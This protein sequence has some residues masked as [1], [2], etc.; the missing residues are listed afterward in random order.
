M[1]LIRSLLAALALVAAC[2]PAAAQEARFDSFAC[3][4][5]D[6]QP[7][8][9]P[10]QFRNPILAGFYPDPTVARVGEDYY[11]VASIRT[12]D[13]PLGSRGQP[14][15]WGRRQQHLS[16][17]ATTRVDF[18]PR[19]NGDR[20][21]IAALQTEDAFYLLSVGR[22]SGRRVVRL[23][24]RTGSGEPPHGRSWPAAALPASDWMATAP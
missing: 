5:L 24:Q 14:S 4:G 3:R 11:L 20:A 2:A 13:V 16:A 6:P 1:D 9:G 10:G 15:Y 18:A 19:A 12:R 21:G 8:V 22:E 23:E 7:R 17:E